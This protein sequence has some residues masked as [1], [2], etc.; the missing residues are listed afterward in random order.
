MLAYTKAI[1]EKGIEAGIEAGIKASRAGII[2]RLLRK[3]KTPEEINELL[4][5]PLDEIEKVKTSLLAD[6]Q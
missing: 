6:T 5:I 3:G 2:E 4:E 1:K